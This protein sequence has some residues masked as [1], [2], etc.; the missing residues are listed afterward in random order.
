MAAAEIVGQEVRHSETSV[1]D[2]AD[3]IR[4]QHLMR[5]FQAFLS[6]NCACCAGP[7]HISRTFAAAVQGP[8]AQYPGAPS[9]VS[10]PR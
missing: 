4:L 3:V 9:M 7:G 5:R 10:G 2:Q 8:T 1:D 6:D